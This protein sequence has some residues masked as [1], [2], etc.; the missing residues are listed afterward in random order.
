MID[1]A[2]VLKAR[3]PLEARRVP[4]R[5][6]PDWLVRLSARFNPVIRQVIGELGNVRDASGAHALERL[7]WTTRA[8]EESIVDCA[9]SLIERGV[10][11][12]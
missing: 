4:T 7:G 3:M 11:R 6:L 10:V 8:P 2:K 12:L 5:R 1:V 9:K